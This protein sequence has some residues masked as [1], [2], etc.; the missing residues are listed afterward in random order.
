MKLYFAK[1]ACS[2]VVRI[3]IN[4]IGLDCDYESVN[5][6]TKKTENNSD[7][8][9]INP[10][11]AVPAF[12]LDN[13]QVLTEN[14]V[15]QQY[16]ADTFQPTKLLPPIGDFSRYQVLECLNFISTELHKGFSNLFN[17]SISQEL[18]DKI[19]IPLIKA[20]LD[21][22]DKQLNKH[23]YLSGNHFTLPDAYLFVMLLW[24]NHFK[25]NLNEWNHLPRYFA[26]LSKRP[27]IVV[28]LREEKLEVSI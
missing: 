14:L 1:G 19:F 6:K 27:S 25:I 18:K 9:K 3:I 24:S 4:E 16:I 17:P 11:G 20:K 7:Y 2:L 23:Q 12:E 22:L 8:L 28:S 5:L 21:Y 15:I 13:G 26:E 10:K